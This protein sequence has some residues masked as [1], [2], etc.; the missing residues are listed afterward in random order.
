LGAEKL[1]GASRV[2]VLRG[3][4]SVGK[5]A[6]LDYLSGQVAG[7]QVARVAGLE[8]EMELANSGLHQLCAPF[9]DHLGQLDQLPA[10]Q[11]DALATV[12]G[13][14][15]ETEPEEVMLGVPVGGHANAARPGGLGWCRGRCG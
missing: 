14:T 12:F 10:P 2:L 9:L 3:D 7:W 11:R 8:S 15:G 4:P 6:L 1:T 13:L 5:I